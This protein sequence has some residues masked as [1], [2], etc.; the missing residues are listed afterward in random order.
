MLTHDIETPILRVRSA[1]P[2]HRRRRTLRRPCPRVPPRPRLRRH[3]RVHHR[4]ALRERHL[5]ERSRRL[6]RRHAVRERDLRP[7]DGLRRRPGAGWQ[8]LLGR[9]PVHHRRALLQRRVPPAGGDE[10]GDHAR[11]RGNARN[12]AVWTVVPCPDAV[13]DYR[14]LVSRVEEV[15]AR[16]P[17]NHWYLLTLGAG[18][19]AWRS[20]RVRR[21]EDDL[22]DWQ[23]AGVP[24]D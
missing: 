17:R 20:Q 11:D 21:L 13:A 3:R 22:D 2:S 18:L 4:G 1:R 8:H 15:N 19:L 10:R 24:G 9:Q 16:T 5:R 23:D 6:P 12:L 7:G 14:P